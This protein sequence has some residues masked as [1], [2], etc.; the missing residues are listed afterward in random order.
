[1]GEVVHIGLF[2]TA[3]ATEEGQVMKIPNTILATDAAILEYTDRDFI[4]NV[5]YEFSI[6]FD[7]DDVLKRIG[8]A[9]EGYPVISIKVNE[10]SDKQFY[11]VKIILNAR[12]KDH[13]TI[14]SEILSKLVRIQRTLEEEKAK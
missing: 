10:Q 6:K 12:E 3:V 2:F 14:K 13:A 9:I 8:A 11:F 1:M 4:F 5:R 7:P